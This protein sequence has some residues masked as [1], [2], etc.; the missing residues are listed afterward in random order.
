ME[1]SHILGKAIIQPTIQPY[2]INQT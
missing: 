2:K 1:Q